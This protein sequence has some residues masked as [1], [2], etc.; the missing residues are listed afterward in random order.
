MQISLRQIEIEKAIVDYIADQGITIGNKEITVAFTAG[1]GD[2]GISA[3]INIE[4][5]G[6]KFIA[7]VEKTA[8]QDIP[9]P[10]QETAK[11]YL[12]ESEEDKE[13]KPVKAATKTVGGL[14][15]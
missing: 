10:T 9:V 14:F 13:A 15:S 6:S 7:E 2:A 3:S 1:R 8:S 12:T 11:Q 4:P 5:L